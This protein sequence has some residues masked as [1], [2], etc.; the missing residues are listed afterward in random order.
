MPIER[1]Q[2]WIRPGPSRA[3]A[4]AK[5][6]PSPA[7]QV[8]RWHADVGEGRARRDRRGRGRRTR[9]PACRGAIS[10]PGVSRG[11]RIID[12]WRCRSADG[13]VLPMTMKIVAFGFIAPV[14]H[15]LRPLMTY[16]SPSR[17]IRVAMLVAS[18]EA[19]VGLGHRERRA[20]LAVEQRVAATASSARR[21]RTVRAPPCCRCRGRSSSSPAAARWLLRP[22]I[23][24][25][26]AYWRL[27]RPAHPAHPGGTGSTARALRAS[28]RSSP[29]IGAESQPSG[30][31]GCSSWSAKTGSAG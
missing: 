9:T 19:T 2:W 22:V 27:V 28:A 5:P 17:S 13:S 4:M 31:A 24:A 26:A 18:E 8:A 7:D 25:R 3:W 11:T 15:H 10:T 1:M 16:S 14:I 30:S 29:M 23:S 21:C 20:D 6:S 12:C